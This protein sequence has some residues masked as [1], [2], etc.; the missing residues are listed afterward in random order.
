MSR[1][2][3]CERP[4]HV[5]VLELTSRMLP[6]NDGVLYSHT[7]LLIVS[8]DTPATRLHVDLAMETADPLMMAAA[9]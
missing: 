3:T 4:W 1:R 2:K 8:T 7:L 5:S 9:A 6:G